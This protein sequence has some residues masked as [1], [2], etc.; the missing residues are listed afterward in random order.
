MTFVL[1]FT[2]S[3]SL[4]CA[5]ALGTAAASITVLEGTSSGLHAPT[6]L[7]FN[8][9]LPAVEGGTAELWVSN[10]ATDS[11]SVYVKNS[12]GVLYFCVKWVLTHGYAARRITL[13]LT[14]QYCILRL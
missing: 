3:C 9:N 1:V 14:V 11:L 10:S 8:P 6:D 13:T 5:P 2:C 12:T 7:H 4:T